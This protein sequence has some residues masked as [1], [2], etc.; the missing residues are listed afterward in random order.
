MATKNKGQ[1]HYPCKL[2][3]KITKLPF[4][5]CSLAN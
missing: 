5:T 4:R 2:F 3:L 1:V